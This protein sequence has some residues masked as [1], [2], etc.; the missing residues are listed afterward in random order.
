MAETDPAVP[1]ID[2]DTSH[3]D[4]GR[5]ASIWFEFTP[6]TSGAYSIST[7]G[8]IADTLISI[9]TGDACGAYT[10]VAGG[11][12]DDDESEHCFGARTDS[13][14]VP[15]NRKVSCNDASKPAFHVV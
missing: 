5:K 15:R 1:C 12:N 4:S 6:A 2:L 3:P 9:W 8:S 14:I 11:C 7:C 10:E 13:E